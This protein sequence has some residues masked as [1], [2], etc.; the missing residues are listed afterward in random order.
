MK[1]YPNLLNA[2]YSQVP[3]QYYMKIP[4][5]SET[6][7]NGKQLHVETQ[8]DSG[9]SISTI[10]VQYGDKSVSFDYHAYDLDCYVVTAN[11]GHFLY[12]NL[13]TDNEWEELFVVDLD[14][15]TLTSRKFDAGIHDAVLTDPENM[16]LTARTGLMSTSEVVRPFHVGEHGVPVNNT[17]FWLYTG[18]EDV[19]PRVLT[20]KQNV[21]LDVLDSLESDTT[22]EEAF[23]TGDTFTLFRTDNDKIVDAQTADGRYVRFTVDNSDWPEIVNGQYTVEDIFD[24]TLFAD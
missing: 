6:E 22:H 12:V 23:Q 2:R 4:V 21:T 8:L 14:E 10:F 16:V 13:A 3:D 19:P 18:L 9:N 20:L 15:D 5:N 1:D 24:N 17:R 7:V 11:S